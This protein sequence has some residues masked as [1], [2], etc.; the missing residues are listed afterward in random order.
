MIKQNKRAKAKSIHK[1]FDN[2]CFC[3]KRSLRHLAK[4][5]GKN[6][7]DE[8]LSKKFY[9][10]KREYRKLLNDKKSSFI[11]NLNENIIFEH[12]ISWNTVKKMRL[13]N[14]PQEPLD[15]FDIEQ[16]YKYFKDLYKERHVNKSLPKEHNCNTQEGNERNELLL[17][18]NDSISI[19][20]VQE[21][22]KGLKTGKASSLDLITNEQL[23]ASNYNLQ[24]A[25]VNLFNACLE[26]GA[27]PWNT[28]IINPL[29]K[30]GDVYNPDDYRGIAIGSILGKLFSSILLERL[31]KFRNRNFPDTLNQL[32]F[33][34]GA[35]TSDHVFT[36]STC[37]HKYVKHARK[38]LY[39]CFVDFRKAFDTVCREA[40]LHKLMSNYG[41]ENVVSYPKVM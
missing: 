7:N 32:G 23:K 10:K 27:Y 26:N 30:K 38:R 39:S 12:N 33:C 16:F 18:I 17:I 3:T 9:D 4:K 22:I 24:A 28:T 8:S 5:Y 15:V 40:L 21:A 14:K 31:I 35:Q 29:F 25:L 36:L 13:L 6:P 41:L 20:E 19:E 1:W 34:R 2:E 37:I 11:R